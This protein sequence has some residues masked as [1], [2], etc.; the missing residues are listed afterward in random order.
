MSEHLQKNLTPEFSRNITKFHSKQLLFA[1]SRATQFAPEGRDVY[2][3]APF[4]ALALLRS[5]IA[6][7]YLG[8]VSTAG[9]RS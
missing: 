5:A 7:A 6:F 3:L 4:F 1:L 2:S 9:F 8:K